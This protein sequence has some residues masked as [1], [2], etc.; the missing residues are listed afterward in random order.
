MNIHISL[1]GGQILPVFIG[2]REFKSSKVYLILSEESEYQMARIKN[3]NPKLQIVGIVCDPFDFTSIKAKLEM[4]ISENQHSEIISLNLTGGTKI[5][6]LAAQS[7]VDGKKVKGYY[8]NQD[9]T[10]LEIPSY[11]KFMASTS[12]KIQDFFN[13]NGH[14]QYSFKIDAD[15]TREDYLMATEIGNYS[16]DNNRAFR[17]I[18][19]LI[20]DKY[21]ILPNTG[22]ENI[23]SILRIE[24]DNNTIKIFLRNKLKYTFRSQHIYELFF[25]G[26]WW[27]LIVF[28]EVSKWEK[29]KEILL[30][31][32]IQYRSDNTISKNEIDILVN[33][34][35]RL[36]FIECK[37]GY[38]KQ[39]DINK[40]RIVKQT[41]GGAISKSILVCR[42]RPAATIVEKCKELEIEVFF[43]CGIQNTITNSL[44]NITNTLNMVDKKI[45]I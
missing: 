39:E 7:V 14:H 2:I 18:T 29:A 30:G 12:L 21:K 19:K 38:V 17:Q 23:S 16:L 11:N 37:S 20:R 40:M 25:K 3:T 9:Y 13:L 26:L 10:F 35:N 33:T 5:M 41:Y 42:Y 43:N 45:G 34:G 15:Y 4:I 22:S 1:V 28:S 6:L 8:L 31:F 36:I 32:E 44:N 24:W 27:E